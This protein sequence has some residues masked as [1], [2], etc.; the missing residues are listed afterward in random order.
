MSLLCTFILPVLT[1]TTKCVITAIYQLKT[2]HIEVFILLKRCMHLWRRLLSK[3]SPSHSFLYYLK[4]RSHHAIVNNCC[5]FLKWNIFKSQD[6][7]SLHI[8]PHWCYYILD[9]RSICLWSGYT[10]SQLWDSNVCHIFWWCFCIK[11]IKLFF[12][13]RTTWQFLDKLLKLHSV[14]FIRDSL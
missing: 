1:T 6:D 9:T 12:S 5:W 2:H 11:T 13:S 4:H 8:T 14:L 10:C 7:I 3:L